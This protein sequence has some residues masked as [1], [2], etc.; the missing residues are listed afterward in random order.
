MSTIEV[1]TY[2]NRASRERS[3]IWYVSNLHCDSINEYLRVHTVYRD[4]RSLHCKPTVLN[5]QT[6]MVNV[7]Y[8]PSR[9][10]YNRASE[11]Y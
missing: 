10:V 2:S 3:D 4:E 9:L 7:S 5:A 6:L 11:P 1:D 8:S